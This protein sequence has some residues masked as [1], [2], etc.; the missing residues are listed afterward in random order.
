MTLS[1]AIVV[2]VFASGIITPAL[3]ATLVWVNQRN[4][5][6][7][8]KKAEEVK[9]ALAATNHTVAKNLSEIVATGNST[10][11]LVNSQLGRALLLSATTLRA[12]AN[13]TKDKSIKV[14]ADNAEAELA[15]HR[16]KQEELDKQL[17]A[18]QQ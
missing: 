3:T 12:L 2:V 13:L 16:L 6:R 18:K 15:D 14:S 1:T 4:A 9:E 8:E 5:M 10:H 17:L 11:V 7:A